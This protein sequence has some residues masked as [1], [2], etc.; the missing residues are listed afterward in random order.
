MGT[1]ATPRRETAYFGTDISTRTW[2]GHNIDHQPDGSAIVRGVEVFKSGTFRDS[3]G[4][5][6]TWTDIHLQQIAQN[7]RLLFDS[8]IFPDVPVRRDHSFSIDKTMGYY[9][10]LRAEGSKL[11]ADLHITD[12]SQIEKFETGHYRSVS[13]EL[14]MY[15][16][17]DETAY[18]PVAM[19]VAY[20][21]IPAVEGLHSKTLPMAYFS[22][23]TNTS[24]E[25]EMTTDNDRGATRSFR[26]K[27]V[28]TSD[29]AAVQAHIEELEKRPERAA[30]FRVNGADAVDA[31]A[32]QAHIDTLEGFAKDT[33]E[34]SRKAFVA[35]LA[36]D[37]K[38][39]ETQ[40]EFLTDL[41]VDMSDEQFAKFT[42][43]YE[44]AP[45][46]SVLANHGA[47]TNQ[48]GTQPAGQDKSFS[49]KAT[50][51]AQIAMH[52]N[53]GLSAEQI[54]N[55]KAFKRLAEINS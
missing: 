43:G 44:G 45:V 15:V 27:G 12:K 34:G 42:K 8:D 9:A 2:R 55:T 22:R 3:M 16:D 17:N 32:V 41:A 19:G 6:N 47:G 39:A 29:H 37:N 52:K 7:F 14:G 28:D 46:L 48:D 51:E 33:L 40:V 18:W 1:T 36:S 31:A 25:T 35:K 38:I 13:F 49:E 23:S 20:V 30:T 53:A 24:K 4:E 26:I 10:D 5:Q 11:V 54:Q 21:D 50:L